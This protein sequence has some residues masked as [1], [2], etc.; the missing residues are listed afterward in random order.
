MK[1]LGRKRK[2]PSKD[3][4]SQNRAASTSIKRPAPKKNLVPLEEPIPQNSNQVNTQDKL[5]DLAKNKQGLEKLKKYVDSSLTY[6]S[7]KFR[8]FIFKIGDVLLIQASEE[9]LIGELI[10]IIPTNGIKEY[11]FW[12]AVQ[13]K[14]YYKKKDINR[15]KNNLLNQQNF[16]SISDYELFPSNHKDII[17][18]E[19]IIN[20]CKVYTYEEYDNITDPSDFTFFT[21]A[22][23]EINTELLHPKFDDWKKGCICKKPL[24]PDQLYIKCDKCNGWYHPKCCGIDEK[25]SDKINNFVC[26]NCI[27]Q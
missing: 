18:I 12:P 23:Y 3:I 2:H 6:D 8:N 22:K 26:P 14:W 20:K 10:K 27:K 9:N 25:D 7:I 21:R 11:P 13:V 1:K 15:K 5:I 17:Y 19:S 24:N 16:D 4:T